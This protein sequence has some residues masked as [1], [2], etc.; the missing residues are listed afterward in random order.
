MTQI[1]FNLFSFSGTNKKNPSI[2]E[3]FLTGLGSKSGSD[4]CDTHPRQSKVLESREHSQHSI[5][6]YL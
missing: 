6:E 1:Y 5:S 2:Q 4:R 3:I